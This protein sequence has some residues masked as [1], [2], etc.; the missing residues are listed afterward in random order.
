MTKTP[1]T[2]EN[3]ANYNHWANEQLLAGLEHLPEPVPGTSLRLLSHIFLAQAIWLSRIQ[4]RT[5]PGSPFDKLSLPACRQLHIATSPALIALTTLSP[6]NL[7]Q[8]VSYVNT[9][10]SAYETATH[11]I[12]LHVFNHGTYHRAQIARDLRQ[13]C[14][15][16]I[17]TDY[18]TYARNKPATG[19][20]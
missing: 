19:K 11:D 7:R 8:L 3:L 5:Y 2:L 6:E 16:P 15:T 1:N 13:Q 4:Q 10:G 12:L 20:G 17:N 18:I 9:Q 14:F